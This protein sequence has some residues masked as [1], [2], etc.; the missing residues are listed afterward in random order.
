M[1]KSTRRCVIL[2]TKSRDSLQT[3]NLRSKEVQVS[4][5]GQAWLY[6]IR[7][8]MSTCSI[9]DA[10][11][12]HNGCP[13]FRFNSVTLPYSQNGSIDGY[14]GRFVSTW[15]CILVKKQSGGRCELKYRVGTRKK[16]D[17]LG[18]EPFIINVIQISSVWKDRIPSCLAPLYQISTEW[19]HDMTWLR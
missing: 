12:M 3:Q 6:E 4:F 2:L 8:R 13:L 16:T 9:R 15:K 18:N 5:Q 1:P 10:I 11:E 17:A 19:T 7:A 14:N